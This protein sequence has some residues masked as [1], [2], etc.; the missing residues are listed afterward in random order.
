MGDTGYS[1]IAL[2][3]YRP[4]ETVVLPDTESLLLQPAKEMTPSPPETITSGSGGHYML[5]PPSQEITKIA[6]GIPQK[7]DFLPFYS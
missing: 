2:F 1:V 6:V 7:K 4:P 5:P 3:S